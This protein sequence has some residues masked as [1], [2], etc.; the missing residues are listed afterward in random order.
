MADQLNTGGGASMHGGVN[1]GGGDFAGRDRES[2][3][4]TISIGAQVA[5][6]DLRTDLLFAKE[7]IDNLKFG[8]FE[9]R[10]DLARLQQKIEGVLRSPLIDEQRRTN[11]LL[12][13]L[14][15]LS[16]LVGFSTVGGVIW[17]MAVVLR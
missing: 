12:H 6:D 16:I 10:Q 15:T 7:N 9:M 1:T 4:T 2:Q 13:L 14:I 5:I 8:Q 11:K 17:I 3:Q